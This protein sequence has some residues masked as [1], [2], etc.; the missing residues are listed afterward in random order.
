MRVE[1]RRFFAEAQVIFMIKQ[2]SMDKLEREIKQ[3]KDVSDDTSF[4]C[5]NTS[6]QIAIGNYR[7]NAN[8]RQSV[9]KHKRMKI[10][11]GTSEKM[12]YNTD[13]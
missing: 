8:P 12:C 3:E 5:V 1:T 7:K 11:C 10:Y 13:V 4:S 6:G 2:R 9:K